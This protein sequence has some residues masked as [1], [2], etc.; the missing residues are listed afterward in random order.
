M[1]AD[2]E[3][4]LIVID[5]E[6]H[7]TKFGISPSVLAQGLWGSDIPDTTILIEVNGNVEIFDWSTVF[8]GNGLSISVFLDAIDLK[9][10]GMEYKYG[11]S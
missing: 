1:Q 8:H 7:T 2:T 3:A 9:I 10:K 6:N 11:D 4:R 5:R